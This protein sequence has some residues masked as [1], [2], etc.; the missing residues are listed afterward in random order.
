MD[1]D[2]LHE[3]ASIGHDLAV[4]VIGDGPATADPDA[5]DPAALGLP[6]AVRQAR[7]VSQILRGA[8]R[9]RPGRSQALLTH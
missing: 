8:L 6:N 4:T 9:L 3:D 5:F 7:N 1:A 2:F